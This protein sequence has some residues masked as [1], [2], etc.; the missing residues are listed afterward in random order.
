MKIFSLNKTFSEL[1]C[2]TYVNDSNQTT[3]GLFTVEQEEQELAFRFAI[4]K[5]NSDATLLPKTTLVAQIERVD[6][7]D[8]FMAHEKGFTFQ[9]N[10]TTTKLIQ[11]ILIN[12]K[13]KSLNYQDNLIQLK[14]LV[15]YFINIFFNF[16]KVCGLLRNGVVAIFGPQDSISSMQVRSICENFEIPHIE[17]RLD[18]ERDRTDLSINFYPH[19]FQLSKVY[20]DL[21]KAWDW[22]SFAIIYENNDGMNE[23]HELVFRNYNQK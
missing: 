11:K 8:S 7:A 6:N 23:V 20:M 14:F 3:G 12:L 4:D 17:T 10:F 18:Y 9:I 13:N 19:P 15:N 16:T 22:K 5:I 1:F 21:I 2:K